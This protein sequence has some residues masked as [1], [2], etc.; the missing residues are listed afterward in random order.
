MYRATLASLIALLVAG[1]SGAEATP[2]TSIP[3]VPITLAEVTRESVSRPV[4]ATGSFGPKDEISLSFKIGGIVSRLSVDEGDVVSRGT[5]IASLDLREIEAQLTKAKTGFDKATRDL[6]RIRAL[7]ADSVTTLAQLQDAESALAAAQA[8]RDAAQVNRDYAVITAP[9]SGRVLRRRVQPGAL[10]AP[11]QEVISL[12]SDSRGRVVRIGVPDRDAVR[13]AVGQSA[14]VT[15]DATPGTTYTGR[16]SQRGAAT[17]PRTGMVSVEITVTGA[18]ALPAGTVANVSIAVPSTT[19]V[20]LVP[21]ESIIEADGDSATV[22]SM[23]DGRAVRHS[24]H[25]L[26]VNGARV[27]VE[28]LDNVQRVVQNGAAY[29]T[30]SAAVREVSGA[31]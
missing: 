14:Q 21:V 24:V 5:V 3:P 30:D 20:T 28:G 13:L 6:T 15:F 27:A 11:G 22:Y 25:I 17:D 7:H 19:D 23:K 16:V 9:V 26:F 12:G 1:C 18:D 8:D 10:V 4:T 29:L 31:K 2:D